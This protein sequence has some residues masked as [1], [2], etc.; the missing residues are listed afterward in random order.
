M[1]VEG[2]PETNWNDFGC[3]NVLLVK[4][5]KLLSAFLLQAVSIFVTSKNQFCYKAL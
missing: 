5:I 2:C 4:T 3:Y 1:F